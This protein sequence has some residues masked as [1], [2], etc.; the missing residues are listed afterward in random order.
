MFKK[1]LDIFAMLLTVISIISA[2]T[3]CWIF[4]YQPKIPKSLMK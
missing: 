2:A 1:L 4:L 3:A